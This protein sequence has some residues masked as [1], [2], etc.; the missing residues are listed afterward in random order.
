MLKSIE[1][2]NKIVMEI[3]KE[4][5][6]NSIPSADFDE[7]VENAPIDEYG[8]KNIRFD[9]YEIDDTIMDNIMNYHFKKN[10]L[11]K[12]EKNIVSANVYLG[13]SPRSIRKKET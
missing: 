12:Y 10:R 4:L 9:D 1:R 6:V 11:T 7:L 5:Y 3:M 13:P 2:L 8:R